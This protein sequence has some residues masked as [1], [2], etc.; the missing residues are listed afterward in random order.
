[1]LPYHAGHG[2]FVHGCEKDGAH[3]SGSGDGEEAI[4]TNLS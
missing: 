1:M 4:A 3:R 2:I